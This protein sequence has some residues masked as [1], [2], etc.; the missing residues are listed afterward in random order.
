MRS[1]V[2]I[3]VLLMAL[4]SCQEKE[5]KKF[6]KPNILW[7]TCE[8]ISPTLS[9]YGDSTAKTP[10]LDR[11]AAQSIIYSNAYTTVGVC[12]PSRSSIITGMYPISIGTQHMRTAKDVMGWGT[13]DYAGPSNAIDLENNPVPRYSAVVPE[14]IRC[15]T[16]YLRADGYY[17]TNNPKTDYQFAAPITAWD[18]NGNKAHWRGKKEEQPFFS[19]FNFGVTHESRL[20]RN[21]DLEMTVNPDS[22]PLPPYYPDTKQVRADVARNYSNIELLDAQIGNLLQQLKEDSLLEHTIIF[23][24]S[25]HGG[26][27]P[28][29][30]REHYTSGLRVPFMVHFPGNTSL[31]Y[32]DELISFVDLAPTMLSITGLTIPDYLQGRAFLGNSS[33]N[34]KRRYIYGSGDRFDEYSDRIRV[35]RDKRY[36]YVRNYRPDLPAY[37][38]VGYRK[39]IK[40]TNELL[41]LYQAGRL[42]N[43]QAYWFRETKTEEEVY[44]CLNDPYN[45]NNLAGAPGHDS[46]KSRLS[47]AM[48]QF[49]A[50]VGDRSEVPE[51][52]M[53]YSMWPNGVQPVTATAEASYHEQ[54]LLLTC[55]TAGA[56]IAYLVNPD[57]RLDFDSG[58]KL[59]TGPIDIAQDDTVY[60][61]A[62]RLGFKES[63]ISSYVKN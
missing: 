51:L 56:S 58:W 57:G 46:I 20:W 41:A 43:D 50:E 14:N 21:S 55:P 52:E 48:D 10:H 54:Q 47:A 8:D 13:R 33:D 59:Y 28:R 29:G 11:L 44:D 25:D 19:V 27:L 3:L 61:Q 12:A 16:E 31:E 18:E 5:K 4:T 62:H 39:N 23:F 38:D 36:L 6:I 9:F 17:C 63:E 45:L 24:F 34:T 37:K 30:K 26:P 53:Y 49:L 22:V 40:M 32:R 15:F 7:I 35:V 60:F 1:L 2:T 42:N